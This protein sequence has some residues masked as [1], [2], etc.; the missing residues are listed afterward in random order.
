[1]PI[2]LTAGTS[3]QTPAANAN[4]LANNLTTTASKIAS[5]NPDRKGMTIYN[6]LAVTVFIDSTNAVSTF[7]Y[8]FPLAA[9]AYYEMPA[10]IYTGDL[11][12]VCASGSGSLSVRELV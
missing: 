4:Y 2:Y 7:T 6:P 5:S 8:M 10:P 1:M 9:K 12:A 11:W 3:T